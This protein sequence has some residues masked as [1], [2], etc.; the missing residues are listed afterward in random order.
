MRHAVATFAS[1][2]VLA[3]AVTLAGQVVSVETT[4]VTPGAIFSVTA[5]GLDATA[6]N[7]R[8]TFTPVSGAPVTVAAAS[9][10]LVD[11]TKGTRRVA[12]RVPGGLETGTATVSILNTVTNDSTSVGTI[13]ILS[14][15]LPEVRSGAPGATGVDVLVRAGGAANF[16]AGQTR[17][18]FGAGLTV[19]SVSVIS[20]TELRASVDIASTA[21][22]GP[23]AVSVT[24]PRQ[25]LV[26]ANAFSVSTA[27]PVNQDPVARFTITPAS[28]QTGQSV[29]F[30][31]T[32]SS[33]PDGDALT[34]E[35][36]F[37]DGT[38][39]TGAN[40]AHAYLAATTVSVTL[41]V[42]DGRG[43][44]GTATQSLVITAP[45]PTNHDPVADFTF[46]PASP[47]TNQA[48]SFDAS[49]ST[50]QD[51]DPL[52]FEW[53]FGDGGTAAGAQTSHTFATPNTFTVSLTVRDGRGGANTT[54]R[55]VVVTA[56][57]PGN[58]P[59]TAAFS[60]SSLSVFTGQDV[61]VDAATSTDP[62]G[63]VLTYGW[64]FGDGTAASGLQAAHAYATAGSFTVTLT[65]NDGKGGTDS[66]SKSVTVTTPTQENRQPT[67]V[68][69]SFTSGLVNQPFAFDGGSSTDPDGDALTY[70]W[71]FGDGAVAA[72]VGVTRTYTA[73]G[74][75]TVTL[76]VSDGRGGSSTATRPITINAPDPSNQAPTARIAAPASADEDTPVAMN[77]LGSSDPDG[78]VLSYVWDFGDTTSGT[79][80]SVTKT[81]AEAGPF[82]ISLTVSDGKGGTHTA[83][84]AITISRV[85]T[86]NAD[87][88]AVITAGDTGAVNQP[89][90]F[91]AGASSDP[92][93]DPLSY[94]WTFGDST[95][96]TGKDTSHA[97][98]TEGTFTVT[99]TVSDGRGGTGTATKAVRISA[100]SQQNQPPTAVIS[101]A[102]SGVAGVELQFDG[103]GS[104]DPD[105]DVLTYAWSFG[106]TG[107]TS[108]SDAPAFIYPDAGTFVVT[109]TV[110]D[111]AANSD[112]TTRTMTISA[113][114]DRAPPVVGLDGPTE[115]LPGTMVTFAASATDNVGVTNVRFE[116]TGIDGV[117]PTD[118]PAA[119]YSRDITL[120]AVVAPGQQVTI[121]AIASDAAGNTGRATAPLTITTQ[122]DSTEPSVTLVAPPRTSPGASMLLVA[123]ASDNR[124]VTRVVFFVD[125]VEVGTDTTAPYEVTTSVSAAATSGQTLT[126]LARAFDA[127]GNSAESAAA[128]PVVATA[129]TTDPSVTLQAP[130]DALPGARIDIVATAQDDTG[131]ATVT[132]AVDEAQLPAVSEAPYATTYV[133][134]PTALPGSTI[135]LR[136][137]ARDFAGNS[138]QATGSVKVMAPPASSRGVVLGEVYSDATGLPLADALVTLVGTDALGKPY[139]EAA[140]SDAR[141]RYVLRAAGGD[142]RLVVTLQNHTRVDRAVTIR[143]GQ[144]TEA[145]DARLTP[146]VGSNIIVSAVLGGTLDAA[147]V[148]LTLPAGSLSTDRA[149][150]VAGIGQQGLANRLPAGW[151]PVAA[152]EIL[153]HDAVFSGAAMLRVSN[154]FGVPAATPLALV[155]Y[156]E[157]AGIWRVVRSLT[158]PSGGTVVEAEVPGGGQYAFLLADTSPVAPVV[159]SDG[160]ELT[161]VTAAVLPTSLDTTVAPQPKVVFYSPGVRSLVTSTIGGATALSSGA[162][163]LSRVSERYTFYAGSSVSSTPYVQDLTF[164]QVGARTNA[165]EAMAP[166]TP[167]L[168]FEAITLKEGVITVELFVPGTDLLTPVAGPDGGTLTGPGGETLVLPF[169]AVDDQTPISISTLASAALGVALPEGVSV[170]AAAQLDFSGAFNAAATFSVPLPVGLADASAVLFVQVR[171]VA[172]VSRLILRGIGRISS[173][174][175]LSDT[176]L[177]GQSFW[178]AGVREPGRY[179]FVQVDGAIS[180]AAGLLSGVDGQ[181]FA[182]G[183]ITTDTLG[184]ASL[185]TAGGNFVASGR[186][187]AN[188]FTA[189]DTSTSDTGH[190]AAALVAGV[191]APVGL[192]LVPQPPRVTS[193]VPS[194]DA[195][196]VALSAPVVV[197]F[198]E[199]IDPASVSGANAANVIVADA[200]GAVLA[201][202]LGLSNGNTVLT[203]RAGTA[204]APNTRYTVLVGTGV[205]DLSGYS[206][207]SVFQS[208][209]E[210]LDTAPPPVPPAGTITAGIPVGGNVTVRATQGT[211]S[212]R[213]TVTIV[214]TTTGAITPVL[215]DPN[216]GFSVLVVA[217]PS[218]KLRVRIV[219]PAGNESMVD[220]GAFTQTN[221]DGSIS[222][223]VDASGGIVKGPGGTGARFK[224]GTFPEGAV[225]TLKQVDPATLPFAPDPALGDTLT[226]QSAL[227]ID[228]GGATP[229]IYVD[230][231]F[232]AR[233]DEQ[234]DDDW[235][236]TQV[237]NLNGVDILNVVDTAKF[238][239]GNIVTSSPPCPGVLARGVYGAMKSKQSVGINYS[240]F[241]NQYGTQWPVRYETGWLPVGGFVFLPFM[242]VVPETNPFTCYPVLTGRATVIANGARARIAGDQL[243]PFHREVLVT[244]TTRGVTQRFPRNVVEYTLDMTG[245]TA[246]S[247][248][249]KVTGPTGDVAV[250]SLVVSNSPSPGTVVFRLDMDKIQVAVSKIEIRN[251]TKNIV[252]TYNI[253][254]VDFEVGVAGGAS[255]GY[256]VELVNTNGQKTSVPFEVLDG[257]YG[258]GNLLLKV[259]DATIDP[260]ASEL[261]PDAPR[262][263]TRVQLTSSAGLDIDVPNDRIIQGG[264]K[265]AFTGDPADEFRLTVHYNEGIPTST[266][267]PSFRLTVTDEQ[268][269]RV[270]KTITAQAPPKDE[271]L[272]LPP[273]S[274]DV[275][276]PM[277][278]SGPTRIN[279]FDPAGVIEFRFS[280]SM[281]ASTIANL[282]NFIV[283]DSAGVVITGSFRVSD[284]N[285]RLTFIPH[286]PLRLAEEYSVTLKGN[287]A[288]GTLLA[289]GTGTGMTDPSGNPLPTMRLTIKTF[290]PRLVG[291]Y[292]APFAIKDVV[293]SKKTVSGPSGPTLKTYAIATTAA[294]SGQPD[295]II[296]LDLTNPEDPQRAGGSSEKAPTKQWITL[297]KDASFT[298]RDGTPFTGDLAFASTFNTYY[299]F[300]D[301]YDVTNP[302]SPTLI[303]GKIFTTNPDNVTG[304]NSKG[305]YKILG[306]GK[307]VAMLR[308][309]Q[310]VTAYIAIENGGVMAANVSESVPERGAA[311]RILEPYFQGNFTDVITYN[312]GLLAIDRDT[313]R[314]EVMSADLAPTAS[315]DLTDVPRRLAQVQGL[316]S[317]INKDGLI[318][319]DEQF[320]LV[321]V[322]AEG[323]VLI[324]NMANP[325]APQV[326]SRIPIPNFTLR[327]LSVD[328]ERRR[329][330]AA[331]FSR[332]FM[333]DLSDPTQQFSS[334]G[335]NNGFDDRVIWSAASSANGVTMDPARGLLYVPTGSG[336][337]VWAVYDNCCD[338]QVDLTARAKSRQV[339]DR[340]TLL[341][342]E[343]LGLQTAI[344]KGLVEGSCGAV[345][346]L[347]QGS[348][349]C[350][351]KSNPASACAENYQPGLSDHDFEVFVANPADAAVKT[352][353]NKLTEQFFDPVTGAP[354]EITLSTGGTITFEDV[355][356]FPVSKTEFE[357]ARLNIDRPTGS[358]GSDN[359]GDIGL[360]RQQLLLKWLLEG[361][362]I[363]VPGMLATGKP[364][365]EILT[366]LRMTTRIPRSEGYEWANLMLFN[367]AKAK[368]Y[369]RVAGA[370]SG[371]SA[372]YDFNIKQL[373]DAGKAGIRATMARMVASGAGNAFV[374]DITRA[375]YNTNACLYI[376]PLTTNPAAWSQ[377]PCGSFEEYVASSAAR[378]LLA[379]PALNLFTTSQV[380]NDV[381]RFYRVK[382]DLDRILTDAQADEF[383]RRA[384]TFVSNVKT[385]TQPAFG[386]EPDDAQRLDN[387]NFAQGKTT[388][389]L[390]GAK[391]TV[392]PH[393]ANKGF[394]GGDNLRLRYF[395]ALPGAAA[396][397]KAELNV[398]LPGGDEQ[399]PDFQRNPDGTLKK[400]ADGKAIPLFVLGPIDVTQNLGT[401]GHIA[402]SIDLPNPQ[403]READRTNNIHGTFFYALD[404]A[405][406]SSPTLPAAVPTPPGLGSLAPDAECNDAPPLRI[407][408]RVLIDGVAVGGTVNVGR[409]ESI[410]VQLKVTN[411][412]GDVINNIVACDTLGNLCYPVGSLNPGQTWTKNITFQV[413]AQ[414]VILEG[415][416]ST[417][418]PTSGIITGGVLRIVAACEAYTAVPFDPDP[419]PLFDA[420][421]LKN[422]STVMRG[423]TALRYFRVINYITGAPVANATAAI[424]VTTANGLFN[425]TATSDAKGVLKSTNEEGV[426]IPFTAAYNDGTVFAITVTKINGIELVCSPVDARRT[427][428]E[429]KDFSYV[430]S[431]SR[432]TFI[433]GTIGL[434]KYIQGAAETGFKV[435][436]TYLTTATGTTQK[437]LSLSTTIGGS[438]KSGV[439][440][441]LFE[442][443]LET[444]VLRGELKAEGTA[445]V[446]GT[447]TRTAKYTFSYPFTPDANC[448]IARISL[449]S[450]YGVNPLYNKVLD[451]SRLLFTGNQCF[452]PERYLVSFG[453]TFTDASSVGATL[454]GKINFPFG[455]ALADNKIKAFT[456]NGS[457]AASS[458][459][460]MAATYEGTAKYV[461][462]QNATKRVGA[463]ESYTLRGGIDYLAS[464][465]L[466]QT[467]ITNDPDIPPAAKP[468]A[469]DAVKIEFDKFKESLKA[470]SVGVA[471][472]T[473]E[474][475]TVAFTYNW[476]D[477]SFLP[478][479]PTSIGVTFAG[480]KTTGWKVT[481]PGGTE[482]NL[483]APPSGS[484]LYT[485]TKPD[486]VDRLT[487]KLANMKEIRDAWSGAGALSQLTF[488]PSKLQEEYADFLA[489]LPYIGGTFADSDALAKGVSAPIGGTA[490]ILG[491][492]LGFRF[493][494][495]ADALVLRTLAKGGLVGGRGYTL[496]KYPATL[497]PQP[498]LDM[499]D[500]VGLTWDALMGSFS[501]EFSDHSGDITPGGPTTFTSDFTAHLT[502]DGRLEPEPFTG[503]L[504][505]WK[506][507]LVSGPV[508]DYRA[509]PMD[510]S[511]AEGR[512]H[513]G[514]GAFHQFEPDGRRLAVATPLM[515]DYRDEEVAGFDE[516]MLSLYRWNAELND[517][518]RL[519][520]VHDMNANTITVPI[521]ELG[522][523]TLGLR[524]PAGAIGLTATGGAMEGEGESATRTFAVESGT[525]RTNDGL[526]VPDGTLY[527]VKSVVAES[528]DGSAYG[529]L[530]AADVDP[531]RDGVQVA[532]AGGRVVFSV[533]YA[534]P[535]GV[536]VPGQA[537]VYAA[538]GTAA[539]ELVLVAQ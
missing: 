115:A 320:D 401:L 97:Y 427:K 426:A 261:P 239:Q 394:R 471:G 138:G 356:F 482:T 345:T 44:V 212:P 66:T 31:G 273:V 451:L 264:I 148:A 424:E 453:T 253:P 291:T 362:Y 82:T 180:F 127:A 109:L 122:Q 263:R 38:S 236:V 201:G 519:D 29:A 171:E 276:P 281:D 89:V 120:P 289:P 381:N 258:T 534:S 105:G 3:T 297:L 390:T 161:G 305:T 248:T 247:Y 325:D 413:P 298:G 389:A 207:A 384:H 59:P 12:V 396:A 462:A 269:G 162:H 432:G 476:E 515:I 182:G 400:D 169:G 237:Y 145:F 410:T 230:L 518:Q 529:E 177:F 469:T 191:V 19:R 497:Y 311:D 81:Y 48:V 250:T 30:D 495:K 319:P 428:V 193:I 346:M 1:G 455:E 425:Y 11:A 102:A 185:T 321:I 8:I 533:R 56:P 307:G 296:S 334:D 382:A 280:E 156:D 457:A 398:T 489:Q 208:S 266:R 213:D 283:K 350:L 252:R 149:F 341:A 36:A 322:G 441:A 368:V 135:A 330:F 7:N 72:G 445:S 496:E 134:P 218:H 329:L 71:Q 520:G 155:R 442:L 275:R 440:F 113:P 231:I 205:K 170:I 255:D 359:V 463:K 137:V 498:E 147:G 292:D 87:P 357:S 416:P 224:P 377:K 76:T 379:V 157:D 75:F 277:V 392:V 452:P 24:V 227:E 96:A 251:V 371:D 369:L 23:R 143:G 414:G 240:A 466:A 310:G 226:M 500:S 238:K 391:V 172:G 431:Y 516:S 139:A 409:G 84:Q 189:T 479:R 271:P 287:D 539:G 160:A 294:G 454:G 20:A 522:L 536:Y 45:P 374:L 244:N 164:F 459:F 430:T 501:S 140:F 467:K 221:P 62:D 315:V 509:L 473:A 447:A 450:L 366:T 493:G 449:E 353:I 523:Y 116:V 88:T 22:E 83:T 34:Y 300:G 206:L 2:V 167:S 52:T 421:P 133:V 9:S 485:I 39:A 279:S 33:D 234:P 103:R 446:T 91:N 397:Q 47:Q 324:V 331:D 288:L 165:L 18:T 190:A 179:A 233:G 404:T 333:I 491:A 299:T 260:P 351:W 505:S 69:T 530:L 418:S 403:M 314:L 461:P 282:S 73:T 385:Q 290:R 399:Y 10:A 316:T 228:F 65:V 181:P 204:L 132:F 158:V 513:Y 438:L 243:A 90:L 200:N 370:T 64:T 80:A 339:G 104:S 98:A 46:Q 99:L 376:T 55:P 37:G 146:L 326:I 308:T 508:R 535:F 304:F 13:N 40:A 302:A 337:D 380:L 95:N 503:R 17:V 484:R 154:A 26:L 183:L 295:K 490:T 152:A 443:G 303:G 406:T 151:S 25:S 512:P 267:I 21:A 209:F 58:R 257:P 318:T 225:V 301:W 192:A 270:I 85:V 340:N 367:L 487:R 361:E 480:P 492:R 502:I 488:I 387:I 363:N 128:I 312:A 272:Q 217:L 504:F 197:T 198:S 521:Q 124:G 465:G 249:V 472:T 194:G 372:F 531:A 420:D 306:F 285:R 483:Q 61:T 68:I 348:G 159:P 393:V 499:I 74:S 262:Y 214:N 210:S 335:D 358:G 422:K 176:R 405:A 203:F 118:L 349:A 313:K 223:A 94:A 344:A 532:A 79:G 112:S 49:G 433:E 254:Y 123:R 15:S 360:G 477:P 510:V 121:T 107:A 526:V 125:D 216:G 419:N 195:V 117:P 336:L 242:N 245:T 474:T 408:E 338:L 439:K 537:V 142:G 386:G 166:V 458:A 92:D 42:R 6:A 27:S 486:D 342:K 365:E 232:P 16:V 478:P 136:A 219:D 41:T 354:K 32:T 517:W 528:T 106:V 168:T 429:M 437:D 332:I 417:M 144:A 383:I 70:A 402:F 407:T 284:R 378:S 293:V 130:A 514:I 28:A 5:T 173:D 265:Y 317:D 375:R 423:G 494:V 274:D 50:D 415:S 241:Y 268:T 141:G 460:S 163:I 468:P 286:S 114:T 525:L 246:D 364:L 174:R 388:A 53:A 60:A 435:D 153:P 538:A 35:W 235:I 355:T 215:I 456:I 470:G 507:R 86:Q 229:Q 54:T 110:T 524:M 412:S 256:L 150:R 57:P 199:P 175:L 187:G 511:G 373:H 126:A 100:V 259:A 77:G 78:D 211:A 202:A 101:G 395:E 434:V 448:S 186:V 67:A 63:D 352:C 131:V 278:I 196:N 475:F 328:G 444:P 14:L 129:D 309:S 527:T 327:G 506:Y 343:K 481:T 411:L 184:I 464:L 436:K 347:E 111:T 178:L 222:T 188:N 119:P 220:L 51:G 4:G 43:G 93:G 108:A 323:A